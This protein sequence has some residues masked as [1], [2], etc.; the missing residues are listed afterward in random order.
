MHSPAVVVFSSRTK[1]RGIMGNTADRVAAD[2]HG[3]KGHRSDSSGH[4]DQEPSGKMVDSTD[5]PN[6]FN[7]R[8]PESKVLPQNTTSLLYRPFPKSSRSRRRWWL[9]LGLWREGV[10]PR[11]GQSGQDWPPGST[12]RHPMGRGG[13]GGLHIWIL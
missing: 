13:E 7:T 11:P 4:K 3:A 1:Q 12:H 2:R 9:L 6:I 5:D 10:H 8:G